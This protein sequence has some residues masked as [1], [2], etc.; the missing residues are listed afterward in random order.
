VSLMAKTADLS[1][2]SGELNSQFDANKLFGKRIFRC[3]RSQETSDGR[4]PFTLKPIKG[5]HL[6]GNNP[7][8]KASI[9]PSPEKG[10]RLSTR[11][12]LSFQRGRCELFIRVAPTFGKKASPE[13]NHVRERNDNGKEGG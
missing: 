1:F 6:R 9:I 10:W 3:R 12:R 4:F 2:D 13:F 8:Y 7:C 11:F 5:R